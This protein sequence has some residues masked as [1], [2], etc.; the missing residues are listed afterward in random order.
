MGPTSL[1]YLNGIGSNPEPIAAIS[2]RNTKE[3][4]LHHDWTYRWNEMFSSSRH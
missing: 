3:T 4:P 2:R 1:L